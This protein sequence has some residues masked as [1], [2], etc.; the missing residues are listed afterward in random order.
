MT[1]NQFTG[2]TSIPAEVLDKIR[3]HR[4]HLQAI[5]ANCQRQDV[6]R[7][8]DKPLADAYLIGETHLTGLETFHLS[9]CCAGRKYGESVSGAT[10]TTGAKR[11]MT[12]IIDHERY[13]DKSRFHDLTEAQA[14]IRDCGPDFANVS[15]S[16]MPCG[17]VVD[18]T[19]DEVG[20]LED[21]HQS[22][23][24]IFR[25]DNTSGYSDQELLALNTEWAE[26][27]EQE[28]LTPGTDEFEP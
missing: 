15:L 5:V 9:A 19:G 26:I 14:A 10:T 8:F 23:A 12:V 17:I 1:K 20:H 13:G 28:D 16:V 6:G 11:A 27:V 4:P 22:I 3:A 21:D 18:Q 7:R 2:P 24:P 25:A